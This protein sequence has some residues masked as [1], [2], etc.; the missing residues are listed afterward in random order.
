MR[1]DEEEDP[2]LGVREPRRPKPRTPSRGATAE[3][4]VELPPAL[5]AIAAGSCVRSEE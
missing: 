4:Q 3:P 5:E 1:S 2:S